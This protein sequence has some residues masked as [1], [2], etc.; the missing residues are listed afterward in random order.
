MVVLSDGMSVKTQDY[1]TAKG[2]VK[3]SNYAPYSGLHNEGGVLTIRITKK[4]R[5]FF[6]YMFYKTNDLK[7]KMMALTKKESFQMY[8][9]P[10]QFMGHS[11]FF[12]KRLEMNF[13]KQIDNLTNKHLK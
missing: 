3:V 9:P 1:Q 4:S 8:I 6:W 2:F 5:K 11:A 12:M 7:W 10:R 13:T